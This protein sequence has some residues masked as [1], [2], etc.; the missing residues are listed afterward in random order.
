[1][2]LNVDSIVSGCVENGSRMLN[3]TEG[4]RREFRGIEIEDME[5]VYC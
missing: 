5:E 2:P 1:M 4:L 3:G